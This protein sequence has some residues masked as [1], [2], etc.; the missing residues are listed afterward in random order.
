MSW[1]V[2]DV[3]ADGPVPGLFSMV[4]I[5][6][7]AVREARDPDHGFL[8]HLAPISS[9]FEPEALAVSGFT[10]EQTL[11]FPSPRQTMREFAKWV[12]DHNIRGNPV[13]VSDNPFF[14]G[15]FTNYYLHYTQVGPIFGWSGRRIGD[16]F[17]G[18]SGH[19]QARWKHLRKTQ[20]D[21]NPL[22]DARGNA[23]VLLYMQEEKGFKVNF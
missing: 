23:E 6:A 10:R 1:F 13:F 17:A 16:M 18:L 3:E 7:V 4:A 21:H 2:V 9:R 19:A 8:G 20:H 22:N 5:G 14:D 15:A 12:D 11:E